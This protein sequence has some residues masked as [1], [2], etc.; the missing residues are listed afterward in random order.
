MTD[1]AETYL[2]ALSY[3]A[4]AAVGAVLI[5]RGASMK[6]RER[7]KAGHAHGAHD[8]D[9]GCGA[10]HGP[11]LEEVAG[12]RS[13]RETVLLILSVA[14]RPCTGAVFLLVIAW[15]LG[16]R[17][18]GAC[19]AVVMG[20]GTSLLIRAVAVPSVSV[21]GRTHLSVERMGLATLMMPVIQIATGAFTL[22]FSIL[23][24]VNMV[25]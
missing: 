16:I 11:S 5:W 6:L 21:R 8:A 23:L 17:L 18:A 10:K 14:V 22:M 9:C 4:I 3:L 20:L 15:Q 2:A 19:A 1:F 24:F 7:N 13:I 12:L 25:R